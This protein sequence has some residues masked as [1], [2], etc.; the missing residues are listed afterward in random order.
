MKVRNRFCM[1]APL[2]VAAS[3]AQAAM[4][5]ISE[6]AGAV[7]PVPLVAEYACG[8]YTESV[9]RPVFNARWSQKLKSG[10]SESDAL[11]EALT[12]YTRLM[13]S[14]CGDMQTAFNGKDSVIATIYARQ[15]PGSNKTLSS[16]CNARCVPWLKRETDFLKRSVVLISVYRTA[17]TL[18][19]TLVGP[20]DPLRVKDDEDKQIKQMSFGLIAQADRFDLLMLLRDEGFRRVVPKDF[21]L[22]QWQE[23][24]RQLREEGARLS[25]WFNGNANDLI[26]RYVLSGDYESQLQLSPIVQRHKTAFSATSPG[27]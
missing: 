7:L 4:G 20:P 27:K 8:I 22:S 10:P 26:L 21:D 2:A 24:E 14:F 5:D 12:E 23:E 6:V 25:P 17:R 3:M 11:K 18:A 15:L 13:R 1:V 16:L 19:P 9:L